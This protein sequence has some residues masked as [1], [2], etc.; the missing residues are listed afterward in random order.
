MNQYDS[1][2]YYLTQ[3]SNSE[4][5]YTQAACYQTLYELKKK[6]YLFNDAILYNDKALILYDSIQNSQ[7]QEEIND[8][9]EKHALAIANQKHKNIRQ[10]YIAIISLCS[11]T[12]ILGLTIVFMFINNQNKK[13]RLRL[14]QDLMRIIADRNELKEQFKYLTLTNNKTQEKNKELQINLIQLWRQTMV[15]ST[16]LFQT[17]D[18]FKKIISIEKCKY[19]PHKQKKKEEIE[20][21]RQD[22]NNVFAQAIQNLQET[23]PDLTHEDVI[24]CILSYLK[25]SIFTIKICM[26]TESTPALTQRKYRIKK[27]LNQETF[28]FIFSSTY[29]K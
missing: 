18:S 7:R 15:I 4:D 24:Y 22:I 3:A 27:Q 21:I 6:Q 29:N 19:I 2:H 12:C 17:T 28:G 10:K 23:F 16:Q 20:N 25:L 14:Q 1:A 13:K 5:I 9:L 11:L 8:I 26:Q